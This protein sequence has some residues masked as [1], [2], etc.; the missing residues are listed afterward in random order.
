LQKYAKVKDRRLGNRKIDGHVEDIK[1][2]NCYF[3]VELFI[4][5]QLKDLVQ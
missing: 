4:V 5:V 2:G 1:V 3:P